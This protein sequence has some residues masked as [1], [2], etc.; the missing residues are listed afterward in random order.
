[1]LSGDFGHVN[2]LTLYKRF[3]AFLNC[4]NHVLIWHPHAIS[5]SKRFKC[6]LSLSILDGSEIGR[7]MS[8]WGAWR[9]GKELS[10]GPVDSQ[11]LSSEDVVYSWP[12]TS[13]S[14][15]CLVKGEEG[16]GYQLWFPRSWKFWSWWVQT[17]HGEWKGVSPKNWRE[18]LK[19][20]P[21]SSL[22]EET[23]TQAP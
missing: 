5:D 15:K 9:F 16:P 17:L 6:T 20:W 23:G 3:S 8:K 22:Q 1:M 18:W 14:R 4:N 11:A 13:A 19:T 12:L 21:E 2:L 7:D 10:T